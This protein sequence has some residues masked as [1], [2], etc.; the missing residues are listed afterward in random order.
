MTTGPMMSSPFWLAAGWT[1]FHFAWIGA[2]IGLIALCARRLLD[3]AR[4]QARYAFALISLLAMAMA[5]IATFV[6]VF[7]SSPGENFDT[8]MQLGGLASSKNDVR[9]SLAAPNDAPLGPNA[10]EKFAAQTTFPEPSAG[11]WTSYVKPL[12]TVLPW[13]W[14]AGSPLTFAFLA[15]GL[16]GAERF[17]RQSRTIETGEIVL[18][19]QRV[20]KALCMTRDVAIGVCDRLVG[21]VLI[22]VLRPMIL[23][24]PAALNLWTI[25]QLEMVL[26]HELAHLRRWDNLVN[27]LQHVVESFLFFHPAVWWVSG[28]ARL[29]RE[30]CC[31]LLVVTHTG[32]ARAYAT[33]LAALAEIPAPRRRSALVA[34]AEN[35]VVL[36]IRR[37]LDLEGSSTTMKLSRWAIAAAAAL[38]VVPLIVVGSYARQIDERAASKGAPPQLSQDTAKTAQGGS[39]IRRQRDTGDFMKGSTRR[40]ASGADWKPGPVPSTIPLR[41]SG[42][43]RDENGKPVSRAKIYL[44]AAG[45]VQAKIVGEATTDAAGNYV[46]EG[47]QVPVTAAFGSMPLPKEI[48]P[49]ASFYVCGR[50][51][52]LGFAW[53]EYQGMYALAEPNPDDIQGRLALGTPVELNLTFPKAAALAGRVVD[54]HSQPVAGCK[55]QILS[56]DLLD[57]DGQETGNSLNNGWAALPGS[58]GFAVTNGQGQFSMGGLPDRTCFYLSVQRPETEST[59]LSLFAA[60]MDGPDTFHQ[61]RDPRSWNGRLPHKVKAGEIVITFPNMRRVAVSLVGDDTDK[62]VPGVQIGTV[63]DDIQNGITS[64]GTTDGDGRIILW[65]PP[66]KYR[67]ICADPPIETHYIRTYDRPLLIEAGNGDQNYDFLLQSG[68]ELQ[69]EAVEAV[70]N[71]P[72]VGAYF[73]KVPAQEATRRGHI[74]EST[75]RSGGARTNAEGILRAVLA[76]E[77]GKRFRFEFA[78]IRE[79]NMPDLLPPE[80][81]KTHDWVA[82][83]PVSE[84]YELNG[85]KTIRLRFVLRKEK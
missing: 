7:E 21:P 28:W 67:G 48:T 76:P 44:C 58:I 81:A 55:L 31:D 59:R 40:G 17:R 49:Y 85:G 16:I 35:N 73:W 56:A 63:G 52:G 45:V 6:R 66:G 20:A 15:T 10:L 18:A 74:Q 78:G 24:P 25:E 30:L 50:A 26:W 69:I 14:L 68:V 46:I 34:M 3:S 64:G 33:T 60:T 13:L 5:P 1:M 70:T 80:A 65:L 12:V 53:S 22:G 77:P 79:P 8:P 51:P 43:A 27:L 37:I 19:C 54:E 2:A 4:P 47:A 84:P 83:Q 32:R 29:E 61:Q 11:R 39:P 57:K 82:D 62:P 9:P 42:Q 36:R 38:V 23:L 75:F 72:I 71:K 41:V